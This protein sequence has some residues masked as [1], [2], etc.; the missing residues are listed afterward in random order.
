MYIFIINPRFFIETMIIILL[1]PSTLD[2]TVFILHLNYA[3]KFS[4]Y[5][6]ISVYSNINFYKMHTLYIQAV[7]S[8]NQEIKIISRLIKMER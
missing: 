5:Y 2:K 6:K 3:N 8:T 7:F 1:Y 4:Y